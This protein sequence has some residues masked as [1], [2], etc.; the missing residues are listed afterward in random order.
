MKM[1]Q[2][3]QLIREEVR[4]VLRENTKKTINESLPA[5]D[6]EYLKDNVTDILAGA[7]A[8]DD[9]TD[10]IIDE[11]GDSYDAVYDSGDSKLI[12]AYDKL[13]GTSDGPVAAQQKAA[14]VLLKMLM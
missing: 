10:N 1:S 8:G 9:M 12:K 2:F 3:R 4:N 11:L 13:R 6:H 14:A 7:A 5:Q